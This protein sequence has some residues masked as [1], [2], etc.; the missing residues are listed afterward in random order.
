M[1]IEKEKHRVN[2]V[3]LDKSIITGFVYINPGTRIMDF[4]N[5][6]EESFM[7]VTSVT[8]Q[9]IGEIHAFKLYNELNKKRDTIFLNKAAVKWIGEL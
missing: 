3:C 7:V 6:S 9:N 1:K 5:H 4:L 2:I 8:F